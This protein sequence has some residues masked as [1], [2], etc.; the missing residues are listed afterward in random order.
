LLPSV[1]IGPSTLQIYDAVDAEPRVVPTI[2]LDYPTA[3]QLHR[4]EDSFLTLDTFLYPRDMTVARRWTLNGDSWGGISYEAQK[5]PY[6]SMSYTAG[7]QSEAGHSYYMGSYEGILRKKSGD[8]SYQRFLAGTEDKDQVE[9]V[10][11]FSSGATAVLRHDGLHL[12]RDDGVSFEHT[13]ADWKSSFAWGF[14]NALTGLREEVFFVLASPNLSK[15]EF[16]SF[17][18]GNGRLECKKRQDVGL[19]SGFRQQMAIYR[20]ELYAAQESAEILDDGS[21]KYELVVLKYSPA[22]RKFVQINA[23]PS[24]GRLLVFQSTITHLHSSVSK[25]K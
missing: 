1:S 10:W 4:A 24:D 18:T 17:H 20:D 19:S 11:E 14:G 15:S 12:T 7:Y 8:S 3:R 21:L 25:Y 6:W 5:D 13:P 22:D 16:C 23:S 2:N 9:G